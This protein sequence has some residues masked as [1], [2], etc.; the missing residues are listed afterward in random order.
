MLEGDG[1][2][3]KECE[4]L[5]LLLCAFNLRV[6]MKPITKDLIAR[7]GSVSGA[8]GASP[9]RLMEVKGVSETAA[10]HIRATNLPMQRPAHDEVKDRPVISNRAAIPRPRARRL[11]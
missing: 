10:S 6:D 4:L 5:E 1:S 7:F 8:L 2:G 11:S 9:E 3:L